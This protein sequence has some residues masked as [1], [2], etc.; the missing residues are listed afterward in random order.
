MKL[1]GAVRAIA[2]FEGAKG[3][4]A[5]CAASGLLLLLHRDLQALALQLV[6]HLHLN[7]AAHYPQVFVEAAGRLQDTR[8]LLLA[9]GAAAYAALRALEAYGLWHQRPWAEVLAAA[10]GALYLPFE[11]AELL[12]NPQ[13]IGWAALVL[14]LL[15]VG[16][17]W[18]A[19]Q[20]RRAA[21]RRAR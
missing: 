1:S 6:Q 18:H 21:A 20:R 7:P 4:L 14:N 5:L 10:S 3:L 11:V 13:A 12:R 2:L 9:V 16:V 19:L 15:V 17:M 8:L